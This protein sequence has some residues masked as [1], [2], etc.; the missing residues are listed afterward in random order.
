MTEEPGHDSKHFSTDFSANLEMSAMEIVTD[1]EKIRKD[2]LLRYSTLAKRHARSDDY[3]HLAYRLGT[4]MTA[5]DREALAQIPDILDA[6]ELFTFYNY[7]FLKEV[8][9]E[10]FEKMNEILASV[11]KKIGVEG[12]NYHL[13]QGFV[14]LAEPKRVTPYYGGM[15]LEAVDGIMPELSR[16]IFQRNLQYLPDS[17]YEAQR[18]E[19]QVNGF[20]L[21]ELKDKKCLK[22]KDCAKNAIWNCSKFKVVASAELVP[23]RGL[24]DVAYVQSSR[25]GSYNTLEN[26]ENLVSSLGYAGIVFNTTKGGFDGLRHHGYSI[27]R[28]GRMGNAVAGTAWKPLRIE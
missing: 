27:V 15:E 19:K 9:V 1:M 17:I 11:G 23:K 4:Y 5:I 6:N 26:L 24:A 8:Y 2:T 3:Q 10:Q 13:F 20:I 22:A 18:R 21:G 28:T 16:K 14:A 12:H 25:M 7:R